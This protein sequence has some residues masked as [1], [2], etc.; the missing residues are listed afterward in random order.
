MRTLTACLAILFLLIGCEQATNPAKEKSISTAGNVIFSFDKANAP[1]SVKT[2]TA[3]LSR[4]GYTPLTKTIN[5]ISDTS[6][7]M[8]FTEVPVGTW[9]VKVDAKDEFNKVL[10]TGEADVVALENTVSQVNLTLL[11]VS[12]GV[13]SVQINVT[14]GNASSLW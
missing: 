9:K 7:V 12:S 2:L 11:P 4:S 10:Y 14:W 13:G 3:T 8:L 5:I 6:A 1:A